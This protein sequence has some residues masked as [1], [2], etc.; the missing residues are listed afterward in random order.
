MKFSDAEILIRSG[1]VNG[2]VRIGFDAGDLH[3]WAALLDG[4]EEADAEVGAE[5]GAEVGGSGAGFA[6]DWPREGRT[7]Y[8]T[9]VAEDPYVVEVHDAPGT[10]ISV[11]VPI[12]LRAGWLD[13]GR[14]RLAA[15]RRMLGA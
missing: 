11:R 2:A 9:F 6:G 3:D 13:A 8:L 14:E 4:V 1:F 10:Q 15:V 12:D 5:A 7:A